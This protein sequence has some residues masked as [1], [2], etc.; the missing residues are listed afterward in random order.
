MAVNP[1]C[2]WGDLRRYGRLLATSRQHVRCLQLAMPELCCRPPA[3]Q[4]RW[5]AFI[6]EKVAE[7]QKGLRFEPKQGA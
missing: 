3:P 4:E 1:A 2:S 5:L 7:W 6:Q